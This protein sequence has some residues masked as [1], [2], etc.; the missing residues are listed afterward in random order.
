M[1]LNSLQGGVPKQGGV[2]R[3]GKQSSTTSTSTWPR[4]D[5]NMTAS[6]VSSVASAPGGGGGRG[7]RHV[8]GCGWCEVCGDGVR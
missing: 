1:G 6:L 2:R 3:G 5:H 4:S 8:V 7:A